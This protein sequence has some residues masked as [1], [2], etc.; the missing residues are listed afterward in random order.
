[1]Y[2]FM[3]EIGVTVGIGR[4][5]QVL[6][7]KNVWMKEVIHS[8]PLFV[9]WACRALSEAI[10]HELTQSRNAGIIENL[11]DNYRAFLIPIM[12]ALAI[13]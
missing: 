11:I 5:L 7:N 2:L 4:I 1:V 8:L 13:S 12:V 6:E 3:L 9:V 10:A